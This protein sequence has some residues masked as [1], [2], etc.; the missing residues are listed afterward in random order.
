MVATASFCVVIARSVCVDLLLPEKAIAS[1]KGT[2]QRTAMPE[3][4]VHKHDDALAKENGHVF[5]S[6]CVAAHF[7][8][9]RRRC[10]VECARAN[11]SYARNIHPA[12]RQDG[13]K[14][15]IRVRS[16]ET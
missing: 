11:G 2:V 7:F 14:N 9:K 1:R 5:V 3:A 15:E 12:K 16:I 10:A 8:A 6:R 4:A 13:Q